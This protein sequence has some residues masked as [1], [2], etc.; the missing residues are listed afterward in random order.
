MIQLIDDQWLGR[1]LLGADPPIAGAD[2]YT[3]GYWY[4]RLCQAV[5]GATERSGVLSSP[6]SALPPRSRAAAL[7]GLLMLPDT[8]GLLSLRELAPLIG[9]LRER[10]DL[11]I[12]GMEALAAAT[13]LEATV[14]LSAPS[15]RLIAALETEGRPATIQT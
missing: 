10:H 11:N 13:R 9:Q 14:F 1:V 8:I 7:E 6:F 12:L 3:T 4:V 5:L 15:P 2:T